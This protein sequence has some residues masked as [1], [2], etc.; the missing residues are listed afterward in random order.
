MATVRP[1]PSKRQRLEASERAREQQDIET[2]PQ[3][4]GS[5]RY[6][7]IDQITGLPIGQPILI[8]VAD[9]TPKNL[10]ILLNKLQDHVS[11]FGH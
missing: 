5:L 7:F 4:A 1:P 11:L 2:V 3:D 8:P 9:A 6:Q 10:E